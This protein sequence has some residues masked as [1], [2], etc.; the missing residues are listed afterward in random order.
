MLL[1]LRLGNACQVC[2]VTA[3]DCGN[4]RRR[5]RRVLRWEARGL[6]A[7]GLLDWVMHLAYRSN[8]LHPNVCSDA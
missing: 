5:A 8:P 4:Q 1:H 3:S 6:T 2:R 7:S